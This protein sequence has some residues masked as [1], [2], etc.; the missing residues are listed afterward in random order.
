MNYKKIIISCFI[1]FALFITIIPFFNN[2]ENDE[3]KNIN[4]VGKLSLEKKENDNEL[5]YNY[6]NDNNKLIYSWIFN[7]KDIDNYET[8]N[9]DMDFESELVNKYLK[10]EDDMKVLSFAHQGILPKNTKVKIYVHDKYSNNEKINMYYYDSDVELLRYKNSYTV[11]DEGYILI[12]L[13]HCSDYILTGAIVQ[14]ASNNPKN[15]NIVIIGLIVVIL[16][17]VA[18]SLFSSNKK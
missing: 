17:L 13:D 10:L 6:K 2:K 5:I 9:L 1:L 18:T 15:I 8:L 4:N 16:I 3:R 7:K 11:D 14:N 12:N